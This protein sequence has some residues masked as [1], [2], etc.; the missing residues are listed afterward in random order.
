MDSSMP[1]KERARQHL[2][3]MMRHASGHVFEGPAEQ[4]QCGVSF[5]SFIVQMKWKGN[6]LKIPSNVLI[7]PCRPCRYSEV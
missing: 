3:H 5:E 7:T 4:C 2:D 1:S 6:T